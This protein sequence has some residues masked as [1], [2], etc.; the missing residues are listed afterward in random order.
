MP[1][2]VCFD[3]NADILEMRD[4]AAHRSYVHLQASG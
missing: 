4:V 3:R 1:A 2:D